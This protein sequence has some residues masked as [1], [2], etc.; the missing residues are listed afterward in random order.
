MIGVSNNWTDAQN[1]VRTKLRSYRSLVSKQQ[2]CEDLYRSLYPRSTATLKFDKIQNQTD[3]CE[4]EAIVQQ[5]I[6]LAAQMA[7]SLEQMNKEIGE[8]M[9]MIKS[10]PPD[11]YTVILR[12]YTMAES[13]ETISEKTFI[14]IRQCW[15][16]HRR[17]I[18]RLAESV[19]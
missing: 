6:D 12:R 2:A 4:L 3:M 8:I 15:E 10:L 14:S 5:R 18:I 13:M 1:E 7:T 9:E 16:Y 11:E 17:A 19:Q